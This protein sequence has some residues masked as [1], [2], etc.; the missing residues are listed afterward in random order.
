MDS[1]RFDS[2]ARTLAAQQSAAGA[3]GRQ[4]RRGFLGALAA[5]GAGL[6]GARG[7]SAQ[8]TQVS[9][10][11]QLCA[12]N[13]GGCAPGCVCCVYTN[14]I[15][16]TVTN[17]RCRPPGTCSPGTVACPSGQ[18]LG[19]SGVCVAPTT[20]T[21]TTTTTT[22]APTCLPGGGCVPFG[23]AC[24]QN[25]D[26]QASWV[27]RPPSTGQT[28]ASTGV[29]G[30]CCLNTAVA[31]GPC[32]E[33]ADCRGAGDD[34]PCRAV[35]CESGVCVVRGVPCCTDQVDGE[36]CHN[37]TQIRVCCGGICCAV[38]TSCGVDGVCR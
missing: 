33:V 34:D 19:P 29:T 25:A 12:S 5:V 21:T 27:C 2:L 9:C 26:C 15:T 13:P 38:G 28:C 22:A 7:T 23:D 18:V 17:S 3:R 4:T 37:L 20:T 6:L 36:E 31:G 10:G 11:N 35:T 30:G 1:R 32:T 24:D 14:P 8:V 16:G